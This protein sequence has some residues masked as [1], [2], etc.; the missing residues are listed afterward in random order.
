MFES[1]T[2]ASEKSVVKRTIAS[3][4]IVIFLIGTDVTIV[5]VALPAIQSDL[6]I[7]TGSLSLVVVAYIVPFATLMVSAGA[8]SDRLG[9]TGVYL[10]GMAIFAIASIAIATSP[11]YEFALAGRFI[12]G[13]GA[14]LCLPSSLSILR[15]TV[16][17]EKLG[18][19]IALW[20]LSASI[21]VS[22]GPLIG[23]LIVQYFSWRSLFILNFPIVLLA[24][25]LILKTA[26]PRLSKT[27]SMDLLGQFIYIASCSLFIIGF[28]LQRDNIGFLDSSD[29]IYLLFGSALGFIA[30]YL[31]ERTVLNP[32]IP[33][34]LAKVKIF[35][36]SIIVAGAISF[37]NFGLVYCL[38]VYYGIVH[39]YE[40]LYVGLLYLPIMIATAT[41]TS[42]VE[43]VREKLG[44]RITVSA[45]LILQLIGSVL[46]VIYPSNVTWICG[47][48]TFFGL[49]FGFV[50]TPILSNLLVSL[51]P[52][53]AGVASGVFNSVRQFLGAFGIAFLCLF[54][55][56]EVEYVTVNLRAVGI[57]CAAVFIGALVV[58]LLNS[59]SKA[60]EDI[61]EAS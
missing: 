51:E 45:G 3:A 8:L 14:A 47:S 23:G 43:R 20:G 21:A 17:K 30:F 32:I 12:Q 19:A 52:G 29:S 42:I 6:F 46:I 18:K 61:A 57:S 36:S 27:V 24:V 13:A 1:E 15:V 53:I 10:M 56:D 59:V 54:I 37:A 33:I 9:A 49:G 48:S 38:G 55:Y 26:S 34:S 22:T 39:G 60:P 2:K 31:C 41:S 58:Y 4:C 5:N 44:D 7:P 16:P 11:T 40:P 25:W 28:M 35:Q 50:L